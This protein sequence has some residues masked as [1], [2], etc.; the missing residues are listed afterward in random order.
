M[1]R[2]PAPVALRGRS[3]LVVED[4]YVIAEAMRRAVEQLGGR[5][6]GPTST[7]EGALALAEG[8]RPDFALL[9]VD[10]RG[11]RIYPVADALI[12]AG[13]PVV[14]TTGFDRDAMPEAYRAL[15][16]IDKPVTERSLAAVL[17]RLEPEA[18]A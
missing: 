14:F 16:H 4:Q 1:K 12:D 18:R 10:L 17:A 13:A 11:D 6:L 2:I 9:D 7:V 8:A 3:V 5:V 15:P